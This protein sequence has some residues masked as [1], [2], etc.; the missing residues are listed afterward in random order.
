MTVEATP[1]PLV[2]EGGALAALQRRLRDGELP[3]VSL[4]VLLLVIV[5]AI[6]GA[7]IAPHDPNGL[8]LG[9]AFRPPFWAEKGSLAYLLGT[10]NLGR[11][12]LSR[13]I[14]GAARS[15]FSR[16]TCCPT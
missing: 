12:I 15:R 9:N 3:V 11:D 5:A 13:I 2:P 7:A 16:A 6:G 10:D 1:L 4:T 14:A 8:D